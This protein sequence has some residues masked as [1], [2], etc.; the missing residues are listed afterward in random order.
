MTH[1]MQP[2]AVVGTSAIMPQAP[3][4]DAF[5]ANVTSGTYCITEVSPERWDPKKYFDVDHSVRD[6]TYSIIGGWVREFDWN[7]MAWRLPV[8]PT[9]ALQ[10]DE[11]QRWAVSAARAALTDAGWPKWGVDPERIAVILGSAIGG[12]KQYKSSIRIQLP[13]VLQR[14]QE[15]ATLQSL[16]PQAQ[17]AIIEETRA[18]YLDNTFEINEDTMPGELS[19][20][21]AG[22]VANLFNLRGLNYTTPAACASEI[23][24]LN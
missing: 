5:W 24:A 8:P 4:G 1:T 11:S 7:P 22:R 23:A 17:H 2:I 9:V 20:V 13:E 14:L 15:S 16:S 18:N 21:M 10:M 12:E 3:S 6:K 19:N